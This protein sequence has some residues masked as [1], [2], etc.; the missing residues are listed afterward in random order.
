MDEPLPLATVHTENEEHPLSRKVA[1]TLIK[2]AVQTGGTAVTGQS[3]EVD[4]EEAARNR[5]GCQL[6]LFGLTLLCCLC[7]CKNRI[8]DIATL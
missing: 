2:Q 4:R 7:R 1:I 3:D 5:W 6:I 8:Q